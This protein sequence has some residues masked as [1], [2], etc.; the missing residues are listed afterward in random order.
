MEIQGIQI[1]ELAIKYDTPFYVYNL[2]RMKENVSEIKRAFGAD[3]GRC[4]I[5][6]AM[7]ANSHPVLLN[8]IKKF[9]IGIDAVSPLEVKVALNAGIAPDEIL[10][11]GNYES[12]EDLEYVFNNG[13]K[14]NLD[15]TSSLDKLL[16]IGIPEMISFRIN[17]GQGAGKY[18]HIT[19]GGEKA[20]FGI[21]IEKALQAYERAQ[22]AGVKKFGIHTFLG[23][24]ILDED[25]F[26]EVVELLA[27][28]AGEIRSKLGIKFDFFDIGG[29]F[30]INYHK[31]N[32]KFD[33]NT[34][35]EKVYGKFDELMRKYDL[36]DPQL[37]IEPGRY[38][39][40]DTGYLVTEVTSIKDSFKKY[41]GINAGFNILIRPALYG[42]EHSIEVDGK[43]KMKKSEKVDIC[44][45]ICENTDIFT[46]DRELPH[47]EE[48]DLLIFKQAGAYANVM[49]MP[50][51]MRMRTAEVGILDGEDKLITRAEN[52][53]DF[54]NRI[55]VNEM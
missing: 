4:K 5:F 8:I 48:N 41:V 47:I 43:E 46:R 6:Y 29:G 45:Q 3:K 53:D 12:T 10:Y 11:T 54:Y 38:I 49:S 37:Y 30:G 27:E 17:P 50:Y 15:S 2:N 13:V 20:K 36:G 1:S 35:A 22:N 55:L 44:G 18:D 23:S 21:P 24:G 19:T 51:N 26:Q 42:A 52:L 33:I 31:E 32:K 34:C 25:H 28:E 14:I 9:D 16:Q 39:V 7:K 40:G